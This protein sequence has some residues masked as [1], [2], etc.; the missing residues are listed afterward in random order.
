MSVTNAS[1]PNK[2]STEPLAGLRVLAL[3]QLQSMPAATQILSHFGADVI[4]VERPP[5]GDMARGALP[6]SPDENGRLIGAT[7]LR[8]NLGKRSICIDARQ[9]GGRDLILQ[10]AQHVDI[11]AENSKPGSMHRL[12]L[13]YADVAA[14]N[15]RCIYVSVTGFGH[16][17]PTPYHSWLAVAPVV[18]AMSGMYEMKRRAGSA[19]VVAPLGA[20]ADVGAG[21]YAVIGVLLALRQRELTGRGQH[22][23]IAMFDSIIAMTDIVA[24]LWSMGS[25]GLSGGPAIMNGFRAQDGWFVMHVLREVQFESLCHVI[26]QSEL[27]SDPRLATRRG[28]AE[29]LETLIRP[30][31]ETWAADKSRT[32]ACDELS[33]AG[34]PAGPCLTASEVASDPHLQRRRMLV[35]VEQHKTAAG[36]VLASGNPIKMS[37]V[38]DD[39][40]RHIPVLGEHTGD[41]LREL[42]G[43]TSHEIEHLRSS[44]I[45]A[46]DHRRAP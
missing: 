36:G 14:V 38:D 4:K 13:G 20:A 10:L 25:D 21:L 12:G 1:A 41:V 11:V 19:P 27:A 16:H 9:P 40:S 15:P 32:E 28:W 37:D 8:T 42:L 18:E 22:V 3:E 35:D 17:P 46:G 2:P 29:H 26:G 5:D 39:F 6:A 24:N 31:V 23:D 34:V 30:A 44:G 45:I 7:F 43:A 33:S